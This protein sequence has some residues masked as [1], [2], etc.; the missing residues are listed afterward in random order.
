MKKTL[1]ITTLII[2]SIML[3]NSSCMSWDAKIIVYNENANS[4][5]CISQ[6]TFYCDNN[7][8]S[9]PINTGENAT[10]N[11]HCSS[12]D[13]ESN[14][15]VSVNSTTHIGTINVSKSGT[16]EFVYKA[17]GTFERQY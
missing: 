16:H 6:G 7:K 8:I 12:G 1:L 2:L 11:Y 10:F 14:F 5:E 3:I 17:D 4:I 13:C 9:S 15:T